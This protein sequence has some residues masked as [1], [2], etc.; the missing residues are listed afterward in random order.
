MD[1]GFPTQAGGR[2]APEVVRY[3]AAQARATAFRH[4]PLALAVLLRRRDPTPHDRDGLGHASLMG[5]GWA[6]FNAGAG[7]GDIGGIDS[8][9]QRCLAKA[10]RDERINS[11][12]GRAG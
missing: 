1:L 5:Q 11:C 10:G 8:L 12:A 2:R 6:E 3:P 4:G 7:G 9:P